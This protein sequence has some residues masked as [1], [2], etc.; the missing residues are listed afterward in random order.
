MSAWKAVSNLPEAA[1]W[2]LSPA[3]VELLVTLP[4]EEPAKLDAIASRGARERYSPFLMM[5]L[6]MTS[7]GTVRRLST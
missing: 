5:C 1:L 6:S 7:G 4:E 2:R 3:D